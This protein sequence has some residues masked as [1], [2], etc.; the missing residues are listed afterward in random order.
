V[1]L[2]VGLGSG[3]KQQDLAHK[4]LQRAPTTTVFVTTIIAPQSLTETIGST[5]APSTVLFDLP[6]LVRGP[7]DQLNPVS[8]R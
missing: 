4:G 8:R 7:A 3:N 1:L 2:V 5:P 6:Y